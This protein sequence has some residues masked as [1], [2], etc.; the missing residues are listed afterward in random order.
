MAGSEGEYKTAV[1][2][3]KKGLELLLGEAGAA[4]A[5]VRGIL[6][7]NASLAMRGQDPELAP[8]ALDGLAKAAN[9][10]LALQPTISPS[11][12]RP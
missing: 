1:G 5:T 7:V 10:T 12:S 8:H 3:A 6:G 4:A 11:L 2:H 9:H